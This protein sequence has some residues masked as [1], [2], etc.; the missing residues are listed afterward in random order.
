VCHASALITLH[1]PD[2]NRTDPEYYDMAMNFLRPVVNEMTWAS[3]AW[4]SDQ[5]VTI[6]D[7]SPL[8]LFWA[9]QA[10]TVYHRLEGRFGEEAQQHMLLMKDKLRIMSQRWKA[11]GID[12]PLS[13]VGSLLIR[14]RGIFAN[15]R[16]ARDYNDGQ[17]QSRVA[18]Q[19]RKPPESNERAHSSFTFAISILDRFALL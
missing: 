2:A 10:I 18:I 13:R 17:T 9:Y 1:D 19:S 3:G 15:I 6:Y 11:G 12:F 14:D 5:L 16:C 7:A 8:L 4:I